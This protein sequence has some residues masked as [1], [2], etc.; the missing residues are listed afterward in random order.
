M[1]KRKS[2]SKK[3]AKKYRIELTSFSIFL[4]GSGLFFLLAWTFVLGIL[5]GRGFLPGAVTAISDLKGQISKLQGM[6]GNDKSYDVSSTKKPEPDP[7]LAFYEK[8]SSKK[9]EAKEKPPPKR[10]IKRV[11]KE[12]NQEKREVSIKTPSQVQ[13][14]EGTENLEEQAQA[15]VLV[16]KYTIQLAS[17]DDQNKAE[18]M[19]KQLIDRGHA[20][21]FYKAEVRGKTYYRVRCG[22]FGDQSEARIYAKRLEIE[23]GMKGFVTKIE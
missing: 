11:Q 8:L 22:R 4:W 10:K 3:R 14:R 7:K 16:P 18:K 12:R 2:K 21:Y 6:V 19:I 13:E 17:L 20:A 23:E 15:S 5:V 9:D 1:A